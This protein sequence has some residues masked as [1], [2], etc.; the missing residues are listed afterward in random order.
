MEK[1][2]SFYK[3]ANYKTVSSKKVRIEYIISFYNTNKGF[4]NIKSLCKFT[5]K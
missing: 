2:Y 4:N 1:V 3:A 5:Q